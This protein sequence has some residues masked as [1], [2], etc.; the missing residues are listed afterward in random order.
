MP[1]TDK[2]YNDQKELKIEK[3]KITF[4]YLDEKFVLLVWDKYGWGLPAD[5]QAVAEPD[6]T[7]TSSESYFL[8]F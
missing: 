5:G 3:K 8:C 7:H 1:L 2:Y 4:L 6:R